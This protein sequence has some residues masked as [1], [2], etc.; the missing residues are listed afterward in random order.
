MTPPRLL[1]RSRQGEHAEMNDCRKMSAAAAADRGGD[2]SD[3]VGHQRSGNPMNS[4][5]RF[6]PV[7]VYVRVRA[8]RRL[9][10]VVPGRLA[11]SDAIAHVGVPRQLFAAVPTVGVA[12]LTGS[13]AR[14]AITFAILF[15]I[16]LVISLA[17][18]VR[19]GIPL[20]SREDHSSD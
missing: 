20:S 19:A 5:G 10:R 16:M 14:V 4:S 2:A 12:A 8:A 9:R 6:L 11:R 3:R 17:T 1:A 18:Q 15:L 7:V 13:I